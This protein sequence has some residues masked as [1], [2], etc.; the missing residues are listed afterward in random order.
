[1]AK[2]IQ[3]SDWYKDENIGVIRWHSNDSIPP[4]EFI[5]WLY[6]HSYIGWKWMIKSHAVRE[7]ETAALIEE[8]KQRM[9]SHVPDAEEMYEM[10]AAFG[11]EVTVVNVITGQKIK[12]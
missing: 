8:Y 2:N 11:P 5:D 6:S 1:M 12:T 3:R 10:Q 9:A 7:T 4:Q